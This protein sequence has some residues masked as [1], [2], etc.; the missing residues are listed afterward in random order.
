MALVAA[1]A[2]ILGTWIEVPRLRNLSRTHR[3]RAQHFA[4]LERRALRD[5]EQQRECLAYWSALALEREKKGK[6]H[7]SSR[8][9]DGGPDAVESWAERVARTKEQAAWHAK[10]IAFWER[11]AAHYARMRRKYQRSAMYPWLA[12]EPDPPEPHF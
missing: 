1:I 6:A 11:R 5:L 2:L 9:R 10:E 7:D 4:E 3:V 12:V 8:H